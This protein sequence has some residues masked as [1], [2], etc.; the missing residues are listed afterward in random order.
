[1]TVSKS[2]CRCNHVIAAPLHVELCND[3]SLLPGIAGVYPA[4]IRD[5]SRQNAGRQCNHR[6]LP[7]FGERLEAHLPL[8]GVPINDQM[9]K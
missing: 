6:R 2:Q 5:T 9:T 8:K 7:G 3:A 1:M 4:M